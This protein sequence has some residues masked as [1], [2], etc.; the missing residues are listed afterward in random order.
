[1]RKSTISTRLPMII[2]KLII[3]YKITPRSFYLS[4]TSYYLPYNTHPC[5]GVD[6]KIQPNA[7]FLSNNILGANINMKSSAKKTHGVRVYRLTRCCAETYKYLN[8]VYCFTLNNFPFKLQLRRNSF[9]LL[10]NH[11]NNYFV[12]RD[13]P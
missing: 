3:H 7:H 12:L 8:K 2:N 11:D 4:L 5:N 13:L 6:V 9:K 1:M 10:S